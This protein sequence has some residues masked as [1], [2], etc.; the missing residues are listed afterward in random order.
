[1]TQLQQIQQA[2]NRVCAHGILIKENCK[3]CFILSIEVSKHVV[4]WDLDARLIW[5]LPLTVGIPTTSDTAMRT[6]QRRKWTPA[7]VV[8]WA[9][10]LG[11]LATIFW[12]GT[13]IGANY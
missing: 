5:Q 1:M 11:L 4:R 2:A 12:F 7:R 10:F 13:V 8:S 3:H 6:R 9:V